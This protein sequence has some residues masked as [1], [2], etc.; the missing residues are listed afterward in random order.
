MYIDCFNF[1]TLKPRDIKDV[2]SHVYALVIT[3]LKVKLFIAKKCWKIC[4][5]RTF[6]GL[7][8]NFLN[9]T[10]SEKLDDLLL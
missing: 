9:S 8:I 10:V 2:I 5:I 4:F 1:G 7:S 3:E 6:C